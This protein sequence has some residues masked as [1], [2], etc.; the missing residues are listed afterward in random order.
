VSAPK[1]VRSFIDENAVLIAKYSQ[2]LEIQNYPVNTRRTYIGI[3]ADFCR[4]LKSQN[5]LEV[6][7]RDIRAYLEYLHGRGLSAGSVGQK[8]F[9]LRGF[10]AFLALGGLIKTNPARL[11]QTSRPKRRLPK[12]PSINEVA[13]IIEA[14]KTPR[15]RALLETLYGTGCRLAEVSGMRCDDV[16]FEGGI[17]RVTGKG[18]KDRIVLFGSKAKE[19][20][21][22]YLGPRRE[23][24]LFKGDRSRQKL[25]VT[26]ARPNKHEPGVWWRAFWSEY[27]D[28]SRTGVRRFKW[29]GRVSAMSIKEA[30][31]KLCEIVGDVS[32]QP[33]QRDLPLDPRTIQ[34]VVRA[35]VLR[36]GLKG[37]HVHSFRHAFATH[38]LDSGANLR[39]IQELLGHSS[40]SD[41]Q[42]Y[43][44]VSMGQLT[45][46]H[47]KFHPRG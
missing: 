31:E 24:Y 25:G 46:A 29:L 12:F 4:F 35:A 44:H 3:T 36:A 41:T 5:I 30:Q 19:A 20:L 23:G 2:W 16:D 6:T 38:L 8:V 9:G 14:A 13:K 27:S 11:I 1:L 37:I 21:L 26:M 42:I 43:T 47:T 17:I 7:H 33:I 10:F 32:T 40:I 34:R 15:D 22:E 18:D 28:E 45:T 39:A